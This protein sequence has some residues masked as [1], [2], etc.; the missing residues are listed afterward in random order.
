M[1]SQK[2]NSLENV[3][4]FELGKKTFELKRSIELIA[5]FLCHWESGEREKENAQGLD[6]RKKT[7]L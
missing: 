3:T 1:K 5:N 7:E 6:D 2:E 4:W